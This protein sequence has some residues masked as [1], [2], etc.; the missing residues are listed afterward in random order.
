MRESLSMAVDAVPE[1]IDAEKVTR[2]LSSLPTVWD[3]HHLHIWG[4]STTD[5]ALTA[6]MV[7]SCFDEDDTLLGANTR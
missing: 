1:S 3:V 2:F 7:L 4:L 5:V 6:H